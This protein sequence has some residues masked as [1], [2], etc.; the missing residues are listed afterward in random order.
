MGLPYQ[1][2][3]EA[4]ALVSEETWEM[5]ELHHSLDLIDGTMQEEDIFKAAK[6]AMWKL[7]SD[8]LKSF[9]NEANKV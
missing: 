2:L 5:Y 6:D 9:K 1:P 4:R 7:W 8:W 3:A